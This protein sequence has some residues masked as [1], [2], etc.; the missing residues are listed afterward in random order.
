MEGKEVDV[1][2]DT[3]SMAMI[4][5]PKKIYILYKL[6]LIILCKITKK[7]YHLDESGDYAL[8]SAEKL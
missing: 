5:N 7:S 6:G 2:D 8:I 4:Q 1:F 3:I